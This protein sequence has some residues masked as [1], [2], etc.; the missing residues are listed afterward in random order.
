MKPG[1]VNREVDYLLIMVR[2]AMAIGLAAAA[3][4]IACRPPQS[5]SAGGGAS[6]APTPDARLQAHPLAGMVGQPVLIAPVQA[7][8][9][10][11]ELGWSVPR[12]QD[13]IHV[14]DADLAA[15][16]S[17]RVGSR[18]WVYPDALVEAYTRNSMYATD[19]RQL[20]SETL[21]ARTLTVGGQLPEPLATQ[22]RTMI[23]LSDARLVL[24]PAELR[25]ERLPN[26][27]G[28][29]VL[30][31]VLVD[32]RSAEIKWAGEAFGDEVA[33]YG[34]AVTASVASRVADLIAAP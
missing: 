6:A 10:A 21:R 3:M 31:L 13:A 27:M 33:M 22:I 32:G 28:R 16:L 19:P 25:L 29:A 11:P 9:G 5:P 20:N 34:P 14:M 4:A 7:F 18:T 24:I 30:R 23:A 1:A 8:R 15:S 2:P 26:G 12:G 17:E